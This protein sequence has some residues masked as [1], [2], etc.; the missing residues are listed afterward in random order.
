MAPETA[1]PPHASPVPASPSWFKKRWVQNALL[2]A[3]TAA[4]AYAM[5]YVDVIA[6]AREAYRQGDQYMRWHQD[7]E[8]KKRSFEKKF[9]KEKDVLDKRLKKGELT[10]EE[11]N[12]DLEVLRFDRDQAVN[13]SSIKYAYQ[14]Y[15]DAY[16]LFSP[17]ESRWVRRAR[18]LAP[19]AKERWRDELRSR[20]IPFEEYMLDLEAGENASAE[21]GATLIV[22]STRGSREAED[23]VRLLKS[24]GI[25]AQVYDAIAHGRLPQEGL[26]I[27][28]PREKFW[29][30]HNALKSVVEPPL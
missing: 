13:E 7:P 19:A 24:K 28:V 21:T 5:V 27:V 23:C 1:V 17:P 12:Q 3:A 4:V 30:A 6:R 29:D 14:W 26:K 20:N 11:F 16:E 18:Y 9:L 10:E 22:Y 2:V 25:E 8:E 15:K